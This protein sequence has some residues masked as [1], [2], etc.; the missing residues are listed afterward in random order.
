MFPTGH[1]LVETLAV[2]LLT[3]RLL[4]IAALPEG[5]PM[6]EWHSSLAEHIV[7][8]LCP[9]VTEG[10]SVVAAIAV[11]PLTERACIAK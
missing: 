11:A 9:G 4:A 8:G 1:S 2:L 7:D 3:A 5:V 6:A 10:R